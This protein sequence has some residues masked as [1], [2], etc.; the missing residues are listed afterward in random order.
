MPGL[1]KFLSGQDLR[2]EIITVDD[3]S[4]DNTLEVLKDLKN[5][6]P[7]HLCVAHHLSNRG[8]GAALRTGIRLARGSVVVTMDADGQHAPEDILKLIEH[9]PPYDLVVGC[10]ADGYEGVW[11]RNLANHFYNR[12]ASWLTKADIK[13]LTSGFRAMRREIAMHFLP[14]FPDG[15][16]APTTTTMAFL[17]AG[18]N[19]TFVPVHVGRRSYGESKIRIWEDGARFVMVILRMIML[20]DPL[21]IFLPLGLVLFALGVLGWLL[22]IL[23]A[24]R[25]VIPNSAI[26]AFSSALMIWLLG[27][28]S[29]QIA[30]S[31]V[32]YHGDESIVL[33]GFDDEETRGLHERS[34]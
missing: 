32:Q 24:S 20:Y 23:V 18:Y 17:K 8:N 21:R 14:L 16:S 22:G 25:L 29:D 13:D 34:D 28:V 5:R 15:F 33:I 27:L 19:V 2:F 30:G 31:R 12:F 10:R 9:M 4:T 6:Y 3:G 11:Y 26:L 7:D 1:I